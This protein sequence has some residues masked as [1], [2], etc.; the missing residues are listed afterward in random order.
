MYFLKI[1][2]GDTFSF[3]M[4]FF[5]FKYYITELKYIMSK[6]IIKKFNKFTESELR[7]ITLTEDEEDE[8]VLILDINGGGMFVEG[9]P[10]ISTGKYGPGV[11]GFKLDDTDKKKL[12]YFKGFIRHLKH[13]IAKRIVSK[14]KELYGKSFDK[15]TIKSKMTKII[16]DKNIIAIKLRNA[17]MGKYREMTTR[18]VETKGSKEELIRGMCVRSFI[19]KYPIGTKFIPIYLI[20]SVRCERNKIDI[21]VG[22]YELK[23]DKLSPKKKK[24]IFTYSDDEEESDQEYAEEDE[25][26]KQVVEKNEPVKKPE[27]KNRKQDEEKREDQEEQGEQ[28]EEGESIFEEE[29]ASDDE[30]FDGADFV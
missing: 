21:I 11:Y 20:D 28:E 7:S 27:K 23:V 10:V 6:I 18:I 22:A 25:V 2:W 12:K 17:K 9:I 4:S 24:K 8:M 26:P 13:V 3:L 29:D 19:K 15:K 1:Y 5:Y 30:T 14:S 16:D